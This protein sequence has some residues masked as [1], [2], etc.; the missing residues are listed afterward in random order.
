[1]ADPPQATAR[2]VIRHRTSDSFGAGSGFGSWNRQR[3]HEWNHFACALSEPGLV[4]GCNSGASKK[5][6]FHTGAE[7]KWLQ[8]VAENPKLFPLNQ[9]LNLQEQM[10]MAPRDCS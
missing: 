5:Q 9:E 10:S 8:R 6:A 4:P 1:M 7:T 3:F 2:Y